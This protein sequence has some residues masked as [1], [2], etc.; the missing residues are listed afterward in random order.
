MKKNWTDKE[1][2]QVLR[3]IKAWLNS[4]YFTTLHHGRLPH[5][6]TVDEMDFYLGMPYTSSGRS[7]SV[8]ICNTELY[9]DSQKIFSVK[10]FE[11]DE[12]GII[13]AVCLDKYENE[14]LIPIN[15]N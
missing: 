4:R 10:C 8:S 6:R 3:V 9:L 5:F 15:K 13:Y 2:A 7:A 11:M 14:L 12:F 1:L